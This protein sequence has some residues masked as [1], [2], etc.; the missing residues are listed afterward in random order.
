MAVFGTKNV[1]SVQYGLPII[2]CTIFQ[3]LADCVMKSSD[4]K[5]SGK[6]AKRKLKVL[7]YCD[8]CDKANCIKGVS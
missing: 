6:T 7:N 2:I 1:H 3:I 8:N 5:T 4:I